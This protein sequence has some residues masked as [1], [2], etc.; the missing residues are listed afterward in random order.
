METI[1]CFF[2]MVLL[3]FAKIRNFLYG[4]KSKIYFVCHILK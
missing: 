3:F 2:V 4:C 1:D